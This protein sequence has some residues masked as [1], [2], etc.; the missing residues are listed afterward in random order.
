MLNP[1]F[2]C[3]N[4]DKSLKL[5]CRLQRPIKSSIKPGVLHM[6][7]PFNWFSAAHWMLQLG[8]NLSLLTTQ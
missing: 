7:T 1:V 2:Y 5:F 8:T 3:L 6:H 4:P